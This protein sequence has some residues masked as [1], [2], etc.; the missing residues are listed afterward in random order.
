MPSDFHAPTGGTV[1]D[2]DPAGPRRPGPVAN[3]P[4][5]DSSGL[6]DIRALAETTKQRIS[7]R[8]LAQ[9]DE[10]EWLI[11]SSSS[12]LRAVALPEPALMVDPPAIA[13]SRS[14]AAPAHDAASQPAA[15]A[16]SPG[17]V[18]VSAWIAGAALAA[19]VAAV[20]AAVSIP[21]RSIAPPSTSADPSHRAA[22]PS[23]E[24]V[25]PSLPVAP[26]VAPAATSGV[27][28]VEPVASDSAGTNHRTSRPAIVAG[29]ASAQRGAAAEAPAGGA[30]PAV[31][32]AKRDGFKSIDDWL[33]EASGGPARATAN[34]DTAS[35]PAR[36]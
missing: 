14:E 27:P 4:P 5:E 2:G 32:V 23:I 24:S 29:P 3:R 7:Q 8:M 30:A 10:D 19:A 26:T 22:A 16:A 17:R 21:A 6:H 31:P 12:A 25:T 33:D 36:K 20:V 11:S 15:R 13:A 34:P 35:T 28:P 9:T 18:R 1:A